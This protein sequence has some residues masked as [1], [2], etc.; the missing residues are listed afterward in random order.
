MIAIF[1]LSSA[2]QDFFDRREI[3]LLLEAAGDISF[4]LDN[5]EKAQQ[6]KITEEQVIHN[7]KRFRA[8]IEKSRDMKTLTN[9]EGLFVYG[10]P[11]VIN[12]FGYAEDEFINKPAF[13]FFH[14]E[15]ILDLLRKRADILGAPGAFFNFRYRAL[16]KQGHWIWIEG[17]LTNMLHEPSVNALVSNFRDISE[18]KNA[19]EQKEKMITDLV[20]YS[21]NLEQ[22]AY[23]VSHNLR[24]PIANILGLSN[25]L[26]GKLNTKDRE[27]SQEFLYK[28][29][30]QL[31][32]T[33]KDLNKI[34]E[35]RSGASQNHEPVNL[36]EVIEAV[37]LSIA[38]SLL[39]ENIVFETA[40]EIN[41][42]NAIKSYMHSIFYNLITNSIKYRRNDQQ[43]L[44]NIRSFLR[45]NKL[46]LVFSDNGTGLNLEQHGEKV[47]GL[48][49]R[50]HLNVSGKGMGLF[51]V[52]TQVEA[53]E[54]AISL[55]SSP[56]KGIEFTLEFPSH[57]AV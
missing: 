37:K 31:D 14:P 40:L 41:S 56:G 29:V 32:T 52:K 8:L 16:H 33:V 13:D 27:R 11:S 55:K 39:N 20:R 23:V 48:Y 46:H 57:L 28:A 50:F 19:E 25:L 9:D 51:M 38:T 2:Q 24:S 4:A 10:S 3:D 35:V 22:F 18:K 43:L 30:E 45:D 6:H 53:M 21:K 34:L 17:T 36:S 47:F 15:D 12:T 5:F 26:K 44:I 7:E 54:G 42:L 49:Q 1:T